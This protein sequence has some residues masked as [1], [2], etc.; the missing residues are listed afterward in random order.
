MAEAERRLIAVLETTEF[1]DATVPVCSNFT[2][3]LSTAR[4]A[5]KESL[6]WQMTMPV[7]WTKSIETV[8]AAGAGR[9]VEA[10]PGRVLTGLIKRIITEDV[11]LVN[12]NSVETLE[13]L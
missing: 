12:V 13:A 11:K 3:M 4:E 2:G 8:A 1:A 6:H 7:Q 9:F 5:L 10:G